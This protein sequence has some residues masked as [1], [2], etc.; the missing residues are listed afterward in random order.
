MRFLD[1]TKIGPK[2]IGAFLLVAALLVGMGFTGSTKIHAIDEADT[3]LYEKMT[4]PLGEIAQSM[5]S[6]QQQRVYVRD[7]IMTG[8]TEKFGARIKVLDEQVAKVEDSFQKT[9]LT[10]EGKE[11]F[12]KYK[13]A[14]LQYDKVSERILE[15][16]KAGRTKEAE[17][18]LRGEGSKIGDEV[19]AALGSLYDSK[20]KLAKQT[21]DNNTV[22]AD[23]ASRQMYLIMGIA[24]LFAIVMG[25]VLT[26]SIT[27][28]L[29]QGVEMMKEMAKGHLGTRLKMDR[30]DEIGDLARAMDGFTNSL[31]GIVGGLQGYAKGDLSHEWVAADAQDEINPAMKQ[32]RTNLQ[33]LVA[34]VAALNQAAVEGKLATRADA[35]KHQ[36]DFR[37]IVQGVNDCLD[38]VIGPLNV[39]AGYVDRISKGDIPPKITDKYN[40]DFNEI[41]NNLNQCIDAVNA[42]VADAGCSQG[43]R[44]RQASHPRR[45]HQAPGR[46]PQDRAGRE[47]VAWTP[48][49]GHSMSRPATWTASPRAT[50]RPRSRTSTTAT[51]TRSRTT[52]TMHRRRERAG[53]RRRT[54]SPRRPWKA[55]WP[56]A[57]TPPSTRAIS[58]RSSRA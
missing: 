27:N 37:K 38:A 3:K 56:P 29:K 9:I 50:S 19:T 53:G 17:I 43:G 55:S 39:S 34:D 6:F 5:Q 14:S 49:S 32:V 33:A 30:A 10:D 18:L 23:G 12:R 25:W 46:L 22:M 7:A 28:P 52:S 20:L 54:C 4:I 42:L 2:L 44:G 47:R 57:P 51:S 35:T 13:D 1:N 48:S 11:V 26:Q 36:G 41:K 21:S 24:V 58:A 8:D 31:Q 40:G 16:V 15:L 45:C